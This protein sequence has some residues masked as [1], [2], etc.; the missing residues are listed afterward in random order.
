M[1]LLFDLSFFRKPAARKRIAAITTACA[2]LGLVYGLLGPKWYTSVLTI[3]PAKQQGGN[4]AGLLGGDLSSL[5]SSAVD[6]GG[7]ADADRIAAVLESISVSDAVIDKFDLRRRYNV[8]YVE[9]ARKKLWSH[10]DVDTLK[11]P[12]L[13][14]LTCEDSDP[15]FVQNMMQ[16]FAEFGNR[17]F[18]RVNVSSASEEVRFLKSHVAELRTE[19]ERAANAMLQFQETHGIVDID[20]Q[21]KAVVSAM[22]ALNSQRITKQLELDYARTF[23]SQDE[24]S[25]RQLE[26]Q[27]SIV[28]G[29]LRNLEQPDTVPQ[30]RAASRR[31]NKGAVGMFPKAMAVPKLATEYEVLLRDRRV[32]EASLVFALGRLESAKADEARQVST[33]QVLDPPALPTKPSSPRRLLSLAL[34]IVLG[35]ASSLVYEWARAGGMKSLWRDPGHDAAG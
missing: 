9:T 5:A 29:Q 7:G 31:S 10:C 12:K 1:P 23:S 27:I 4:M 28:D 8:E 11:K 20:T 19:A 25:L 26:S 24:A 14:Q 17:A 13:V 35:L 15:R 33:F 30:G 6:L 16:F 18:S 22:A 34:S 2:V 32:T 21:A 3:V